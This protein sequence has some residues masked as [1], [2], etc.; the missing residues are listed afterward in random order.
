MVTGRE[1]FRHEIRERGAPL[2]AFRGCGGLERGNR[3]LAG[4]NGISERDVTTV[5]GK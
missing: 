4:T 5:M 3:R 2:V 1:E